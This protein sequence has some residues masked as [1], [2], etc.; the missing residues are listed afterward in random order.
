[1]GKR[2]DLVNKPIKKLDA[3]VDGKPIENEKQRHDAIQREAGS[4]KSVDI[5]ANVAFDVA[6]GNEVVHLKKGKNTV[7]PLFAIY[8]LH[9]FGLENK[10]GLLAEQRG[11]WVHDE[12]FGDLV[13]EK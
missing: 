13:K 10:Y 6:F 7:S 5:Y 2:A 4:Y 3:E 11:T 1:M 9:K 8:A 12:P